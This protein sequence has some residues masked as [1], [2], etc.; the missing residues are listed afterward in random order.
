M[1][2]TRRLEERE[3]EREKEKEDELRHSK[4]HHRTASGSSR[5]KSRS[6][7]KEQTLPSGILTPLL[8][9]HKDLDDE[10]KTRLQDLEKRL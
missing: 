5:H 6:P 2:V 8:K 4:E 1:E 10:L 7:K 3:R 9:R